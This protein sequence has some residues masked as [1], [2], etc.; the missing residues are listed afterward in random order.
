M[1]IIKKTENYIKSLTAETISFAKSGHTGSALGASTMML[2]LFHDHLKFNPKDPAFIGRDRLVMSAGH[3]S[4]LYYSL[5]H[6]FGYKISMDDLKSFRKYGSKTPGHPEYNFVAGAETTT[7]PLGQG[8]A[9]AV[10][11]AL[12]ETVFAEKFNDKEN[13]VFDNYTYCYTGDGCIMEGVG[14]EACAIAGT[15]KLNKLILLYDNNNITIDGSRELSNT[16]DTA[17]KFMAM[18]WN[19]ITVKNGMDYASCSK[20]ISHAKT[21]NKPTIIIFKTIIGVGTKVQGTC[22]VHAYPLPADELAE[23]KQS[24]GVSESFFLP[25]DVYAFA[26]EAVQKNKKY[27]ENYAQMMKN[28]KIFSPEKYKE[29]SHWVSS[30]RFNPEKVLKELSKQPELAG[31]DISHIVLNKFAEMVPS[32]IGGTADV[33]PSTK[34]FIAGGGD[35]SSANRLGRNIHYGVREHAMGSIANGI[36]LYQKT[37]VFDSTFM[38]FSNY[39]FPALKM[40]AMMQIPIISVFTHDS[41]NIGEDGPTHQPIEQIGSLRQIVGLTVFRPATKAETVAGYDYFAKT[42]KPVVMA[43]TKSKLKDLENSTVADALNGG[44]VIYENSKKPEVII[45]ATGS[46]VALAVSVANELKVPTRVVSMPCEKLFSEQPATTKN[47]ILLKDA[48]LKVA[49]EA[50]DDPIWYKYIG[51]NGLLVNVSSYQCSGNGTEVYEKA[52]FTKDNIIKQINKKLKI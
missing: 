31:R 38:A 43:M 41:L 14:M 47:K 3:T 45:F 46:E 15:L 17:K 16:E 8:I 39:M 40:R 49:I 32:T 33:S 20:A 36:A 25:E 18:G 28:L 5:L 51:E 50:S 7:G 48:K 6:L 52:G 27:Y 26:N 21:S 12:A 13:K 24:L 29:I 4:A 44:Y 2:A 37:P 9:N 30:C 34:A 19:V 42:K 22:K 1:D 35:Y 11:L 10:G 23:F